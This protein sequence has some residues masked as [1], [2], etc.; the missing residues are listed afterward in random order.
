[1]M[2]EKYIKDLLYRYDCII[3]PDFG[4]F[5]ANTK[6]AKVD[7]KNFTPPYKQITFN[8]LI[9]NNDGLLANHIAQTD[10]IPYETAVNFIKFEVEEWVNRL[11]DEELILDGLGAFYIV[12]D[13]INF[14]PDTSINYLTASFGLSTFISNSILRQ[15]N[16]DVAVVTLNDKRAEYKSQVEKIEQQ[17]PIYIQEKNRK[18]P[19]YFL[20]YAAIFMI[21]ASIIGLLGKK[22][23]NN[24]L[25]KQ[26]NIA[27]QK[28]QKVRENE[29]QTAT[30]VINTPLPTITVKTIE[31]TL[32]YH[33]IAGAFRN[34]KNALKKVKHLKDKGF[35]ASV[36]G[37]NKWN[38]TQVAFQSFASLEKANETL[39]KIKKDTAKDAWLLIKE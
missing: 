38:L 25:E 5:I 19:T 16:E 21:S 24:N 13:N 26:Q 1:M 27:I 36:V 34:K 33:I 39:S 23:Y 10:K 28:Q 14:E 35:N 32:K 11:L 30:F 15:E 3:V 9:Q 22:A 8:T 20:K 7:G 6:S 12:N 29:I 31:P 2:L 37:K 4:A 17:A 18:K